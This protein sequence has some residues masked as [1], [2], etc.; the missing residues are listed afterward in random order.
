MPFVFFSLFFPL[1]IVLFFFSL[2][3]STF[4]WSL[5]LLWF[6]D[7]GKISRKLIEC[8]NIYL[9]KDGPNLGSKSLEIHDALQHFVFRCWMTTR[10]RGL[11]VYNF[12]RCSTSCLYLCIGH[13]FLMP[14]SSFIGFTC[15]LCK[16]TTK[17]DERSC[18]WELFVR[19]T[20]GCTREGIRSNEQLQHQFTLVSTVPYG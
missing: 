13:K 3:W 20:S 2:N 4:H 11:K 17:F 19:T 10:D 6:R 7:E 12:I 18:W 14:V 8:I 15:S 1:L 5:Y 9:L 16:A